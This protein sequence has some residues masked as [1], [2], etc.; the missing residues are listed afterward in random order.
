VKPV[1]IHIMAIP[2]QRLTQSMELFAE[3][4][5][6]WPGMYFEM[7]GS[8]VWVR[9]SNDSRWQID[10]MIYDRNDSIEYLDLKG[11]AT[12]DLWLELFNAILGKTPECL[13]LD[14]LDQ[15]LRV[16]TVSHGEYKTIRQFIQTISNWR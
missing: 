6:P 3:T 4:V 10:G 7:D 8:F 14:E 16:H 12:G 13:N 1:H 15:N 2:G 9:E 5:S 11:A